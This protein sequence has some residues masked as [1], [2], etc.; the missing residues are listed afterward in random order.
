MAVSLTNILR[1]KKFVLSVFIALSSSAIGFAE[2]DSKVADWNMEMHMPQ[3]VRYLD[4]NSSQYDEVANAAD[5]F[6]DKMKS[7]S[8]VKDQ[9]KVKKLNEAVYGSF[10]LMKGVLD[11]VQYKKY[12]RIMNQALRNKGLDVYIKN[13][14]ELNL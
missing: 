7:A 13:L 11:N 1:M 2:N 6:N 4:L 12:I 8:Y 5:Y 9:R 10:K 14:S 3:L